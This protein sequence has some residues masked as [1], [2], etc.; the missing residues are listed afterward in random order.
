MVA[1]DAQRK[2]PTHR[3]WL[4]PSSCPP[5]FE[6]CRTCRLLLYFSLLNAEVCR[7][8]FQ[9]L[10][11]WT[12]IIAFPGEA[13]MMHLKGLVLPPRILPSALNTFHAEENRRETK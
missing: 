1:V 6:A 12:R 13:A 11:S 10:C 2:G 5:G 9:R 3:R 7:A 4:G 8:E